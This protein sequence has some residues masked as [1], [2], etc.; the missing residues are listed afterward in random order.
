M[1]LQQLTVAAKGWKRAAKKR[2]SDISLNLDDFPLYVDAKYEPP[3]LAR[4]AAQYKAKKKPARAGKYWSAY[5]NKYMKDQQDEKDN[6][7]EQARAKPSGAPQA[8]NMPSRTWT[9]KPSAGVS[10]APPPKEF[11]LLVYSA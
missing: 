3:H 2:A 8:K 11:V 10:P 9:P 6:K 5:Q 4:R 7:Y 1:T